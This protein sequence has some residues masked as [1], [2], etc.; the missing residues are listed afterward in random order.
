MIRRAAELLLLV[1]LGAVWGWA[2]DSANWSFAGALAGACV[3]SVFD[4]LR[5]RRV[6]DWLNKGEVSRTPALSGVWGEVLE[7][8]RKLVAA[9]AMSGEE[10][11][12]KSA[13]VD[14][15]KADAVAMRAAVDQAR[16]NMGETL[17]QR[18]VSTLP[19]SEIDVVIP[20]PE[21]SRPSAMQAVS[22]SSAM[23]R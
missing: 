21:S 1:V 14:Q 8:G 20:I 18:V 16:L 2:N 7:R 22:V 9:K 19:P 15:A 13:E 6:L 11:D 3:W 4:G 10:W 17:A 12:Q 5:A 23:A